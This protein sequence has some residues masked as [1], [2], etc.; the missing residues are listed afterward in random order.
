MV[1]QPLGPQGFQLLT[2]GTGLLA[3]SSQPLTV[4]KL[5]VLGLYKLTRLGPHSQC[6]AAGGIDRRRSQGRYGC[7]ATGARPPCG[8]P[9][10]WGAGWP[11]PSSSP[12]SPSPA[13]AVLLPR[14][15][16]LPALWC[17]GAAIAMDGGPPLLPPLRSWWRG[18]Q[19]A[20]PG[21]FSVLGTAVVLHDALPL[22]PREWLDLRCCPGCDQLEC[23]E[24]RG[25]CRAPRS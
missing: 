19:S 1:R 11:S 16:A 13:P 14:C 5:M 8:R 3:E 2:C 24:I 22:V 18:V 6:T 25:C 7:W 9:S 15:G 10:I 12:S 4:T 20:A 23:A 17:K 21:T